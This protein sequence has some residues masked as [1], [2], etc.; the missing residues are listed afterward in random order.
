MIASRAAGSPSAHRSNRARRSGAERPCWLVARVR[1][2]GVIPISSGLAPTGFSGR[3]AMGRFVPLNAADAIDLGTVPE[4]LQLPAGIAQV[5]QL[6]H[7]VTE[8][9]AHVDTLAREVMSSGAR[10]P[11]S[12]CCRWFASSA[13]ARAYNRSRRAPTIRLPLLCLFTPAEKPCFPFDRGAAL[14][15]QTHRHLHGAAG[16]SAGSRSIR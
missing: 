6:V 8:R 5:E 1:H 12:R 10:R 15:Q 13:R 14:S 7:S 4:T 9:A 16:Q 11:G 3:F 2:C